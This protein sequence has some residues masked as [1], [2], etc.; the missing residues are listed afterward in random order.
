[1]MTSKEK[2]KKEKL[3]KT[4][5]KKYKLLRT[6]LNSKKILKNIRQIKWGNK[7]KRVY[8][9]TKSLKGGKCYNLLRQL[10]IEFELGPKKR[11]IVYPVSLKNKRIG[12]VYYKWAWGNKPYILFDCRMVVS[13]WLAAPVFLKHGY[14]EVIYT[15]TYRYTKV[16]GTNRWSRH[17]SGMAIDIKALR[18]PDKVIGVVERDWKRVRGTKN[19]CVGSVTGRAKRMR[20]LICEFE[21]HPIFRR[22]L[23][24]DSDHAHRDHFHVSGAKS[25]EKWYRRRYAGRVKTRKLAS[26]THKKVLRHPLPKR[27]RYMGDESAKDLD[28][29]KKTKK[30]NKTDEKARKKAEKLESDKVSDESDTD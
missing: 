19:N 6:S 17:A 25:G 1:G 11:G 10:G 2:I 21:K 4:I 9:T 8:S 22:I 29:N 12:G 15:S 27:S 18:G 7:K 20:S 24:P 30:E 23:T 28:K 16:A 13:L 5:G 26:Y 14:D 3:I